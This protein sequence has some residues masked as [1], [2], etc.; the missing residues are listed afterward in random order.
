M[1][2]LCGVGDALL[3]QQFKTSV[4][5]TAQTGAMRL[6]QVQLY[7]AKRQRLQSRNVRITL[8]IKKCPRFYLTKQYLA[9]FIAGGWVYRW[10]SIC[11][12]RVTNIAISIASIANVAATPL[13]CGKVQREAVK[14][15]QH[16]RT[17]I[18]HWNTN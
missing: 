2:D 4:Q 14:I 11:C 12:Q 3:V 15:S 18:P 7:A 5:K 1:D 17:F 9:R 16:G 8:F 13:A 6:P 10:A